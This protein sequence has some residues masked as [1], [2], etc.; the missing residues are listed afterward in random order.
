[1]IPLSTTTISV[2]RLSPGTENDEPYSGAEPYNRD[3]VATGIRAVID[4][5]TGRVQ[6]E[7]GQQATGTFG[8][9][10]DPVDLHYLDLVKDDATGRHFH[11][12]WF[13]AYPGHVEAG[14]RDT[15]GEV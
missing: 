4:S 11:L 15:E 10:C 9:K 12:D 5:A 2:L 14:L 6:L 8:L 13:I 7:G 1:M 3:T